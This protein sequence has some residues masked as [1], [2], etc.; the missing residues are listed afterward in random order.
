MRVK[1]CVTALIVVVA[2]C[3]AGLAVR[4][5]A[6]GSSQQPSSD[7]VADAARK[8]REDKKTAPKPKKVF[9]DD[10][11][12][13]ANSPASSSPSGTAA[14]AAVGAQKESDAG[15]PADANGETAWRKRF[16]DQ[17]DKIDKAE[18][19]LDLLQREEEKAQVQYY[20]DPQKALTEQNTRKDINDKQAKIDAKKLEI[21]QLKQGLDDLE[22]QLRKSG[23]DPGWAR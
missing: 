6:Q 18:K 11:V 15:Q 5:Q 9:T 4:A 8:A 12:K 14:T 19:E 22:D 21:A 13:P 1:S 2:L 17:H 23:G 20:S 3:L 7:P 16:K 10:D